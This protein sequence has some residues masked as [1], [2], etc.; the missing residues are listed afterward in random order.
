MVEEMAMVERGFF[1]A[2]RQLLVQF[3]ILLPAKH[4]VLCGR[5]FFHWVNLGDHPHLVDYS[6][7]PRL[8]AQG[9]SRWNDQF[10]IHHPAIHRDHDERILSCN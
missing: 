10:E 4:C 6:H 7:L 5:I 3:E 8:P 1:P 2:W 9:T